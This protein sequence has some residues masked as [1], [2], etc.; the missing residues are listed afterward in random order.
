MIMMSENVELTK[1]VSI[2]GYSPSEDTI[3]INSNLLKYPQ[4]FHEVL[5]HEKAHQHNYHSDK[6]FL[7]KIWFDIKLDYT[8]NLTCS[9][10]N[11]K[12]FY[13]LNKE[14]RPLKKTVWLIIYAVA[15][16]L[17]TL[18]LGLFNDLRHFF[19]LFM[20]DKK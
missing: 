17:A 1:G 2:A 3:Y 19:L 6:S 16:S 11:M 18:P 9:D 12:T 13:S 5:T 7:Q 20:G 15:Y 10:E 14:K 8:T 4:L